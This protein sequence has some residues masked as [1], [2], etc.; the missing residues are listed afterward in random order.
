MPEDMFFALIP[1]LAL[2]IPIV[3]V[4]TKHQQKMAEIYHRGATGNE[5]ILALRH[6]IA[7]LKSL[8]HQQA[9]TLDTLASNQK[10]L[11]APPPSPNLSE[12]LQNPNQ[13]M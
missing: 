5:D 8:V 9:I 10:T 4:F 7:E 2:M 1:L 12:R 6:E 3:V 11:N 13:G